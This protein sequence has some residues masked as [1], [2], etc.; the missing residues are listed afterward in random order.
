[1]DVLQLT[2]EEM[3]EIKKDVSAIIYNILLSNRYP[4][5]IRKVDR[6]KNIDEC[7]APFSPFLCSLL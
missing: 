1:M 2:E 5:L 7:V 6:G 4:V 3:A